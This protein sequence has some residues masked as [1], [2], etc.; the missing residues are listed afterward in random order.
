MRLFDKVGYFVDDIKGRIEFAIDNPHLTTPY[1]LV[2]AVVDAKKEL[3][4]I[5]KDF[6]DDIIAELIGDKDNLK[7]EDIDRIIQALQALKNNKK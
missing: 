4:V 2:D 6:K 1:M 5:L 3:D 7:Q